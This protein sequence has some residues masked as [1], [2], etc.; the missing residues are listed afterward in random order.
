M[1]CSATGAKH[2]TLRA[3]PRIE[4]IELDPPGPNEVVVK[5]AGAGFAIL[6]YL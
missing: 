2:P 5:I 3:S 6:T 4:E 1:P